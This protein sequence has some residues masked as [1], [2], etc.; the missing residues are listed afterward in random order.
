HGTADDNVH[1]QNT[2][3]Y[4]QHL[5]ENNKKFQMLLYTDKNHSILGKETR[6]HLYQQMSEFLFMNL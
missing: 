4:A 6:R 3:L 2:L 1:A 5:E